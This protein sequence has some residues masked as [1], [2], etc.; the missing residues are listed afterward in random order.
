[1][2]ELPE[3]PGGGGS[4]DSPLETHPDLQP[5]SS[6]SSSSAPAAPEVLQG[7]NRRRSKTIIGE[8]PFETPLTS[9]ETEIARLIKNI[10]HQYETDEKNNTVRKAPVATQPGTQVCD[11]ADLFIP[12]PST[13][14]PAF[15]SSVS[16]EQ[17]AVKST[18][19]AAD[20]KRLLTTTRHI[21]TSPKTLRKA[22]GLPDLEYEAD[23]ES[24]WSSAGRPL[25]DLP[26][27][28]SAAPRRQS[29][30]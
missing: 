29:S 11:L 16:A 1:M 3:A 6:S 28:S 30:E 9:E 14:F 13:P 17:S 19:A 5:S 23:T 12:E 10:N 4:R 15:E 24:N 7:R 8:N 22:L 25:P 27:R 21:V 26:Q 18:T 20:I 2:A